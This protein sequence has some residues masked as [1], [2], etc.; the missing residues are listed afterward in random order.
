MV[1]P[2]NTSSDGPDGA[3]LL[4]IYRRAALIRRCGEKFL[5]VIRSGRIAAPYYSA[6]GQEV[7]A[8]A[9]A[10]NLQARDYVV[11]IYRGLHDHLA[12]GVPLKDALGR[13]RG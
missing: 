5:Q 6:R 4:E 3:T 12:K 11:T 10:V 8:A 9:M 2:H 1:Q 7:L 13:I